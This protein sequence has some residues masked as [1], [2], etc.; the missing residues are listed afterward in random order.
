LIER[1]QPSGV[2][3]SPPLVSIVTPI[4]NEE[5][6]LADCIESVLA[7]TYKQW[8]LTVV[9]NCSTDTSVEI[10]RRYAA[11]DSRIRVQQNKEFLP[12]VAN[13]NRAMR[14]ISASSK[15]CKV[16]LGDDWIFPEC[17]E[18]MVSVAEQHPSVGI[19]SA[20]AL[21][22]KC[23][24]WTGL[25]YT[26]PIVS[27]RDICRKHLLE[28]VYVFGT[29]TTVLYRSD[30]VRS[31]VAFYNETDI[32][33]DTEVCFELLKES[34]FAFVHQVL[35]FTREREGSVS[36]GAADL[37]AYFGSMLYILTRHGKDY[38]TPI[39][40]EQRLGAHLSEY[41]GFLGKSLLVRRDGRFW[42]YH[43]R[44]LMQ[45]GVGFSVPRLVQGFIRTVCEAVARPKYS[46]E[47]LL[48]STQ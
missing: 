33:A 38:L 40:L 48:R 11:T 47:R 8:T 24:K 43:K 39:E 22:G 1:A 5:R 25:P 37:H 31:R 4:Y 29:P 34:D 46:V 16:I 10:A 41:Y 12:A 13:H 3:G 36:S 6:Y 7:Q 18:R 28:G 17:I 42:E 9:D 15:Y 44:S 19:V 27:G 21:E 45:A 14:R 35:T 30:L 20:Y 32:H 26:T 23:V 2:A